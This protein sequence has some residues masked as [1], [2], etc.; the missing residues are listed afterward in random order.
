MAVET[1]ALKA[2]D[3]L[4]NQGFVSNYFNKP[5]ISKQSVDSSLYNVTVRY[6]DVVGALNP[7]FKV[8]DKYGVNVQEF[9]K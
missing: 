7:V 8:F 6:L 3:E 1:V 2:I 5:I 4:Q 9:K